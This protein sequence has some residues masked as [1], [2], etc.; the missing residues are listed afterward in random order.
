MS[1]H[2]LMIGYGYCFFLILACG[3]ADEVPT[4]VPKDKAKKP[5]PESVKEVDNDV[6]MM[7]PPEPVR[8]EL[9]KA[10]MNLGAFLDG[11]V[12]SQLVRK[13]NCHR[14]LVFTNPLS[15]ITITFH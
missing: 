15:T 3:Y 12:R 14:F 5:V 9:G 4:S 10:V 11:D 2:D 6:D 7:A 13:W 1:G 8:T